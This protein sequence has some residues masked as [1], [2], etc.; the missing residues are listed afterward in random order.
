MKRALWITSLNSGAIDGIIDRS[1]EAGVGLLCIRTTSSALPRAINAFKKR[2]LQVYGWRWPAV[3]PGPHSAPHYFAE[4]EA[5]YVAKVLIPEGLDGYIVDPESDGPGE[6]DD[7][8][9]TKHT[10][11]A[12]GFCA[13]IRD[14]APAT[15]HF[16]VTSGCEYPINHTR[17]PWTAFVS[18]ADALYPQTYW[19]SS[20]SGSILGGTPASSFTR[21]IAAWSKIANGKPIVAM[22]GELTVALPQEIREFGN[23]A[24][25]HK[26][27]I[28]HFYADASGLSSAV[29]KAIATV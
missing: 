29:I 9:D 18:Y 17:I 27:D 11:L 15:F 2:G 19:R 26:Q 13:Q 10:A 3:K 1:S 24:R 12:T 8:N 23:L 21:G 20:T 28:A 6:I 22:A 25:A 16:G 5:A 4:D 7:W 14:A